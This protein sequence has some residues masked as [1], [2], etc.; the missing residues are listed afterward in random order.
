[1][2]LG[3]AGAGVVLDEDLLGPTASHLGLVA[4]PASGPGAVK[5]NVLGS[6]KPDGGPPALT[7]RAQTLEIQGDPGWAP[8]RDSADGVLDECWR[9]G[10]G[11]QGG[12]A[13]SVAMQKPAGEEWGGAGRGAGCA[14]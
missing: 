14:G 12:P 9:S 6:T 4:L 8:G 2:R 13:R 1:M 3:S 5:P 11:A 7:F 10:A